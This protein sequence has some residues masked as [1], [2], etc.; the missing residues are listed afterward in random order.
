MNYGMKCSYKVG[1][2]NK[3]KSSTGELPR[4]ITP[5]T[6]WRAFLGRPALL[7]TICAYFKLEP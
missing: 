1:K 3:W 2:I 6:L 5:S 7:P 4:K